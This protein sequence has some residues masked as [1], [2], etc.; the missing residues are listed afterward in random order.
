MEW[1]GMEWNGM[2]W[3]GRVWKGNRRSLGYGNAR[4]RVLKMWLQKNK[5]PISLPCHFIQ[6]DDGSNLEG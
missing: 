2:E 4:L 5:S 3:N 1:N 6:S